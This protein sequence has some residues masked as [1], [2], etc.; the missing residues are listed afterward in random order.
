[1]IDQLANAAAPGEPSL[2][3]ATDVL[4]AGG[5]A[6]AMGVANNL[7]RIAEQLPHAKVRGIAD[8]GWAPYGI[9]PYG[10]GVFD[11]R[12]DAPDA[13]AYYNAQPDASCTAANPDRPGACL[14]QSFAFPHIRT[15]MFVLVDQNDPALLGVVGTVPRPTGAA[16]RDYVA[17]Y[18]RQ[19]RA[20]LTAVPAYFLGDG[21]RHTMLLH[22]RFTGFT[23]G[24]LSLGT[25][26]RNWYFATGGPVTA[27]AP[28]PGTA[29]VQR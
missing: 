7:D 16:E 1:M 22:P 18:V 26:L 3:E 17:E 29:G 6:G 28:L 10:P 12:P 19:I 21:E 24:G 25:V 8:A 4:I 13:L 15:P 23:A 14:S 2:K 11:V 20:S 27:M 5:S 9:R